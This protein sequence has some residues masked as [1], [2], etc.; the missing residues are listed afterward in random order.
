MKTST[1]IKAFFWNIGS[2]LTDKKIE[3]L[4]EAITTV[5]PDIFCIAE[6]SISKKDCKRIVEGF[7]SNDYSCYYSPLFSE[8]QDLKPSYN[9]KGFGL[10]I[11]VSKSTN[12]KTPFSFAEQRE[13]GRIVILKVFFKYKLITYVFLHNKSKS[14]AV[15]ETLDQ[16]D[17]VSTLN[18]MITVGKIADDKERVI[19]MGDFNLEPWDRVLKHK[20]FLSTSFIQNRNLI[21]QRDSD[22]KHFFNPLVE[23]IANTNIVNLGGTYYSK[24]NGWALLDYVLYDTKDGQI[25]YDIITKFK[26]G[27]E[28]LKSDTTLK[29]AFLDHELDHLPIITTINQ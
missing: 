11:F 5:S 16:I 22:K 15:D 17:F 3:L 21:N 23:L 19:I 12:V 9:Y 25:S 8:R 26:G 2:D 4:S 29:K 20:K 24:N 14:G 18:E 27:S 1:V 13:E 6:G 7:E 28:L 10:K